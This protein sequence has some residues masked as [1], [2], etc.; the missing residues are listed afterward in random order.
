[1]PTITSPERTSS[2]SDDAT[3]EPDEPWIVLVWNDPIN[4]MT[5]VTWVLQTVFGYP[6]S[7]AEKLMM[8]VHTKGK[9]VVS[10][11]SKEKAELDVFRLHEHGLWATMQQDR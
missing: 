5:Y 8:D 11:G 3:V 9:A 4:L 7:K 1:M 6:K 2:P 10:H